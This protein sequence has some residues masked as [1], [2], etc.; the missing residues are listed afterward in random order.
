MI[1]IT[2]S[3]KLH[4]LTPGCYNALPVFSVDPVSAESTPRFLKKIE[5]EA[6]CIVGNYGPKEH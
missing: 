3:A 6:E 4:E 5:M 1:T 2:I